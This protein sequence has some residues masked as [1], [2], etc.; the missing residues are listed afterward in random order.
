M[1]EITVT[2]AVSG[3]QQDLLASG[4]GVKFQP[5]DPRL[6]NGAT[7]PSSGSART[8]ALYATAGALITG[9]K[10]RNPV[11]A[12]GTLPTTA[13]FGLADNT[14]K[15]LALSGNL[16]A[17][18]SWG[19]GVLSFPFTAPFTLAYS[20]IYLPCYVVNGA[21]GTTQ[22]T[23]VVMNGVAAAAAWAADGTNPPPM[24]TWGAQTDLPAVGSSLTLNATPTAYWLALY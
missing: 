24:S 22:P 1:A 19:T 21:W 9:I 13:R 8:I 10:M 6:A 14:G 5:F 18:A 16:N 4:L 3:S 23:P 7:A 20:G 12:A 2:P 11:A 15:I 17:L